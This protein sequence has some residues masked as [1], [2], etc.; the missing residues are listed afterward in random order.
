MIS[1]AALRRLES[2]QLT[3]RR[4]LTG[5]VSGEHRSNRQGNS[6]DFMDF[7]DYQPG[8]DV[9]RIDTHHLARHDELRIKLFESDDEVAVRIVLDTS[10]SM[11]VHNKQVAAS[12]VVAALGAVA[13]AS[14]D[15]VSLHA[16]PGAPHPQRFVGRSGVPALLAALDRIEWG[17]PT[18]FAKTARALLSQPGP[19]GM[20]VVVSDLLT[21][22]WH[23][24]ITRLPARGADLLVVHVGAAV[25]GEPD[26]LGDLSL[27]DVES[28]ELVSVSLTEQDLIGY[29]A[30]RAQWATDVRRRCHDV[31]GRYLPVDAADDVEQLMMRSWRAGGVVR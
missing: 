13:M 26:V 29:R 9:R 3:T 8:D 23:E 16:F 24:T 27:Q 14:G 31:G 2:L 21:I 20:T 4:R 18:P 12:S 17:G 15:S 11:A 1:A 5:L 19:A 28:G 22:D 25:E 10:A 30:R 6:L 7:R